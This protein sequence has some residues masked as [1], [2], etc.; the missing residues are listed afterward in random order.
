MLSKLI[1]LVK[2]G[3]QIKQSIAVGVG[4]VKKINLWIDR[5]DDDTDADGV[6]QYEQ[7]LAAAK[8]FEANVVDNFIDRVDELKSIG[9]LIKDWFLYV[10]KDTEA[11]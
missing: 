10:T 11:K 3:K 8:A 4:L 1:E 7:V 6:A 5:I 2:N 9:V